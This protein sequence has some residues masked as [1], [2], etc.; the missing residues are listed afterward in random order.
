MPAS[1]QPGRLASGAG[2]DAGGERPT[3]WRPLRA[4]PQESP[5]TS[6]PSYRGRPSRWPRSPWP[7]ASARAPR[8]RRIATRPGGVGGSGCGTTPDER[9]GRRT[10]PCLR[11]ALRACPSPAGWRTWSLLPRSTSWPRNGRTN[12]TD[13]WTRTAA[14]RSP[15]STTTGRHPWAAAGPRSRWSP[16]G[17]LA[18][19]A[20]ATGRGRAHPGVDAGGGAEAWPTRRRRSAP[21]LL[22]SC[23]VPFCCGSSEAPIRPA[24]RAAPVTRIGGL[25]RHGRHDLGTLGGGRADGQARTH[26][27]ASG[28]AA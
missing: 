19:I 2:G 14:R 18:G 26:V 21:G 25:G 6:S 10:R 13:S 27:P 8:H 15:P 23:H 17:R 5:S 3:W 20:I 24:G 9:P 1:R 12:P 28:P 4:P 11:P 7:Q 22:R 16:S